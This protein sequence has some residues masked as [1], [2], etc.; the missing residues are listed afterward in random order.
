[1]KRVYTTSPTSPKY[2]QWLVNTK[3]YTSLRIAA[4]SADLEMR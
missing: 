4:P 3:G 2:Q 1:M